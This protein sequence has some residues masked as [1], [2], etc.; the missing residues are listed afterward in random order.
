MLWLLRP[1]ANTKNKVKLRGSLCRLV[2]VVCV[3]RQQSAR[4]TVRPVSNIFRSH[5]Y[6]GLLPLVPGSR[7][8]AEVA[9]TRASNAHASPYAICE[10]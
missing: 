9:V 1:H 5:V 2:A 10:G 8:P 7:E 4:F 6:S 3:G